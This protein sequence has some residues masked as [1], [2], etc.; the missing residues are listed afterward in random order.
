MNR[1]TV[2]ENDTLSEE[3]R[4]MLDAALQRIP[5]EHSDLFTAL[6]LSIRA[7][8]KHDTAGIRNAVNGSFELLDHA[9]DAARELM[10][11]ARQFRADGEALAT[12]LDEAIASSMAD[13]TDLRQRLRRVEGRVVALSVLVIVLLVELVY[14]HSAAL[15]AA[16]LSLVVLLGVLR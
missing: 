4:A 15:L 3:D 6:M 2:Q 11:A 16:L 1:L 5:S 14:R 7:I 13:R 9:D 8:V 12:R 10:D